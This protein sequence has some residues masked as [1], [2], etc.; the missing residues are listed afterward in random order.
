[1]ISRRAL[2]MGSTALAFA[3][4]SE[5]RFPRG[6]RVASVFNGGRSS[7]QSNAP[8]QGDY[9][10]LDL[11]KFSGVW[12]TNDTTYHVYP[13]SFLASNGYPS[14]ITSVGTV[15]YQNLAL[16]PSYGVLSDVL[17]PVV[18][19]W[20]GDA[21]LDIGNAPIT[22]SS[23]SLD[24]VLNGYGFSDGKYHGRYV[25][26]PTTYDSNGNFAFN[27]GFSRIT[28]TPDNLRMV[29][30]AYEA[31]LN[32]GKKFNPQYLNV[33][34]T[35]KFG[36]IRFMDW[37]ATNGGAMTTWATRKRIAGMSWAGDEFRKEWWGGT[38]TNSGNDYSLTVDAGYSFGTYTPGGAP[39]P[40][41]VLHLSFNADSTVVFNG[42]VSV[43]S[44]SPLTFAWSSNPLVNGDFV[45][46]TINQLPGIQPG[47]NYY[48]VNR[49]ASDFQ[50]SLTSGGSALTAP[51]G[52]GSTVG[53]TKLPTLNI[54]GSGKI[55]IKFQNSYP[56]T[57]AIT[58]TAFGRINYGTVVYDSALGSFMLY[59]AS[60][61]SSAGLSNQTPP[62]VAFALCVEL[63]AHPHFTTPLLAMDPMTDWTTGLAT[64]VQA[65][66]PSW[67]IPRYEAVNEFFNLFA[68][69]GAYA[70]VIAGKLW[71]S[72]SNGF[73]GPNWCGKVTSTM[74]QDLAAVHGLG[75]LGVT[76]DVMVGPGTDGFGFLSGYTAPWL[77]A[78]D[79][80]AQ[81]APA[82]SGYTK[83]AAYTYTSA[84]TCATYITPALYGTF[85]EGQLAWD[86]KVTS[87]ANPTQQ[88]ADMNTYVDSL[89]MGIIGG[90]SLFTVASPGVINWPNHGLVTG[91]KFFANV[92]GVGGAVLPGGFNAGDAY[93][94]TVIDADHFNISSSSGGANVNF[95]G[96]PSGTF[97]LSG[98]SFTLVYEKVRYGNMQLLGAHYGVNKLYAYEG[99]YSPDTTGGTWYSD[100]SGAT[101]ALSCVV[102]TARTWPASQFGIPS[103]YVAAT[104]GMVISPQNVGGMTQLN[105][106]PISVTFT[107]GSASISATNA[108]IA[109]QMV[110]FPRGSNVPPNFSTDLPYFVI[111]TGL[112]GSAFQL[113][114]T[115]GGSAITATGTGTYAT[116][117]NTGWRVTAVN[118]QQFTLDVDSTGFGAYTSG[119]QAIYANLTD[120]VNQFRGATYAAPH[121]YDRTLDNYNNYVAMGGTF[122]S[123]YTIAGPTVSAW[124]VKYPDIWGTTSTA[125]DAIAAFNA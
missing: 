29:Y 114:L 109:G 25:W 46:I 18:V 59:G 20:E 33:L 16:Y 35:A 98:G 75:N 85:K 37:F 94:G 31:D 90:P 19:T 44:N 23:G 52:S 112:S 73:N 56:L 78:T 9:P 1:M 7:G 30:A 72:T 115:K 64:Y 124:R 65:N 88:I 49:T 27:I 58:S 116:S 61:G 10:F 17:N 67:M 41:M 111:A 119:G 107:A 11:M 39:V 120:I 97:Y 79:Y 122:P 50:I 100:M 101:N 38:T 84:M 82:Q 113:S 26:Y 55:P 117:T 102:T 81:S 91:Q 71:Y 36:V 110:I 13:P 3:T 121:L 21:K 86:W 6:G 43:T 22:F 83:T 123:Q 68:D 48:V 99:G 57:R 96:T 51:S 24:A 60:S 42:S 103:V 77:E 53:V 74:G 47:I 104:V 69:A 89:S 106:A 118:G 87:A 54:N 125:Y 4:A 70:S 34:R 32:A 5:A 66:R 63:G 93:V 80:V 28:A 45:G 62:E 40:G 12:Q 95:T 2:L 92:L 14:A 15:V 8:Y 105:C 108:L 76:Y